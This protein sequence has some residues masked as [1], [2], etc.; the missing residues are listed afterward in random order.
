MASNI[1]RCNLKRAVKF[2]KEGNY[3]ALSMLIYGVDK[4]TD[5]LEPCCDYCKYNQEIVGPIKE[6]CVSI[7][8]L[9][10]VR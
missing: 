10:A 3:C 4:L 1:E 9:I 7:F 2:A 6:W 5:G 8:E